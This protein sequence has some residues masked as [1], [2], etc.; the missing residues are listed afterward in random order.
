MG[1][2]DVPQ[3]K[4]R[5]CLVD[6]EGINIK[7]GMT[8]SRRAT[9]AGSWYEGSPNALKALV[10]TLFSTASKSPL[11]ESEKM[12][13]VISPH[14]GISYS[15]NTASHVYVHLRDY[16]YG[17]KGRSITRIFLLGPSHHKGFD[18][19]EVCAAQRYETPF[20]PLVVNAK[21]GQEV[22]KE[23]RAAGV[24]VGTMHRMTDEDEHS[25]EMQLPFISHLLHYPPNG[26]KP[27][28]DRVELVPLLIGG[29]NRKMENLIGSVLSKYL[30]DNQNFFVISSDFCHWGARF[31]YMYHYEKAEYPDIGDAII[32]MDHEG[33]RLLEARDMDGW[34]KYLSTT[35]NTICGRR[36]ISVLM[37]ALDSKKEAV[38]RFLHYSQSNR[39]KNMSDSSV[40][41][42][43]A[44]VTLDESGDKSV[45]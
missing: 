26:Y 24:P 28:M 32:S 10:D 21:V 5:H 6:Q 2:S 42:A 33:M 1:S 45:P 16:I 35:N 38:V 3:K 23:L 25:I 36:P 19:V 39:C 40:S 44:I 31:Q 20:G 17:H 14:A 13:G 4:Q 30:K 15:G 11:K 12:I 9:H 8:Y 37:A 27:A 41:Y 34:Y 29:T 43:G 22:E 18:G 7:K